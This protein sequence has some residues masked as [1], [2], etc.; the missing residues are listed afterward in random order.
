VVVTADTDFSMLLA[1]RRAP[2]PSVI[3][4]RR[5]SELSPD[6]H[7]RLLLANLPAIVEDL[8]RGVV[9]SLSPTRLAIRNLP[10]S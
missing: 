1:L 6:D 10:I 2:L 8:D 7:G 9:V 3:L 5:V 4:L